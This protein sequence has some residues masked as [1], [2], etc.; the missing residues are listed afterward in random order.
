MDFSL[1]LLW[2]WAFFIIVLTFA[3]IAKDRRITREIE[4]DRRLLDE[5]LTARYLQE[6]EIFG[7]DLSNLCSFQEPYNKRDWGK[8]GF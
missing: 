3:S 8:N 5:Y 4:R 7:Q 2:L 6:Q 1:F